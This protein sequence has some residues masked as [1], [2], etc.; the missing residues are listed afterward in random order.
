MEAENSPDWL[1]QEDWA[2]LQAV[3]ELIKLPLSLQSQWPAHAPN[4]DLVS[5]MVNAVSRYFRGP[6]QC[7]SR[8]ESIIQ[9][10]EEGRIHFD[11]GMVAA[12]SLPPALQPPNSSK[13]G[14]KRGQ[15]VVKD[16]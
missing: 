13:K 6:R 12:A 4:W 2:L 14:Q 11:A 9:P 15:K 1:I 10:R 3:T 16:R 7:K 8:Y 5:D